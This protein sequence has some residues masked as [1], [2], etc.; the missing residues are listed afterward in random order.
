MATVRA[1]D[2]TL[3]AL[4]DSWALTLEAENKSARTVAIY[5]ESVRYLADFL[6]ERGMPTTVAH[7]TREHIEAY[8][9]HVLANRKASTASIRYR[10][11]RRFFDW[12]AEDGEISESP[13]RNMKVRRFPSSRS[14][15]SATPSCASC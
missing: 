13:M 10:S 6:A 15:C 11:L 8:L 3:A 4:A 5:T 2:P 12:C 7:L 9:A 1:Y 14:R